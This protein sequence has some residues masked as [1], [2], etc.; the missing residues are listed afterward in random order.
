MKRIAFWAL[1]TIS[2]V[3]LLFGYHTSTSGAL[4]TATTP[5]TSGTKSGGSAG[6]TT[7]GSGSGTGNGTGSGTDTGSGTGSPAKT[8]SK[9]TGAVANTEWGPVQVQIDVAG[10]S[11]TQVSVLQYPAGN[12]RD[13]EINSYALP[14]LVDETVQAQSAQIDMVSGATVTSGGYL[15][16][17]QSALDQAG[18]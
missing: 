6:S 7:S 14:I 10:G 18:L 2:A 4:T 13:D 8:T 17:L 1:S 12:S 5:I 3:V 16:S 9:V 11:I 15:Q